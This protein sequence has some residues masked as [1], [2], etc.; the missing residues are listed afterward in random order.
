LAT[1]STRISIVEK[2][3]Q[4]ILERIL[5]LPSGPVAQ[6]LHRKARTVAFSVAKW[7]SAPPTRE[8]RERALQEVLTLNIEVMEASRQARRA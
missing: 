1:R 3:L 2:S 7:S 6:E 5:E 8:E 4:D